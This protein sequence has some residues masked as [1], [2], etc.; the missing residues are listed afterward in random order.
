MSAAAARRRKQ[1]AKKAAA[2]ADSGG[3]EEDDPVTLR[4]NTLLADTANSD[5]ST[6]YEALQLAQSQVRRGVKTGKYTDATDLAYTVGLSLLE[7]HG[8]V[9][10]ASQLLAELV[11]VLN[12][13]HTDCTAEWVKRMCGLDSAYRDALE[14]DAAMATDERD[15]LGR[16]HLKFLRSA[17]KWSE[18]LGTVRFGDCALH[19]L[20]GRHCWRMSKRAPS[21][22]D[23]EGGAST[24]EEAEEADMEDYEEDEDISALS[25]RCEAV[26]HL[27]LSEK[28]DIL[29]EHLKTLPAPTPEEIKSGH[30]CPPAERDSLLTRSVLVLAAVENLRDANV[31]LRAYMSDIEGRDSETLRKS[32]MSKTDGVAPS[33]V[34]FCCMVLRTCEKSAKTGPLYSWLLRSFNSELTKIYKPDVIKAYTTKIGKVYFNIQPPPSMMSTLENM[35][36]MMGGGGM[37]GGMGGAPGGMNPA[38]MQAMMQQMQGM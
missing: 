21:L 29:A 25:L 24:D 5:E 22:L 14:R 26:T 19:E 23:E 34:I 13:T 12:E 7:K 30:V 9:S 10:V 6:A 31:L 27:A 3:S 1:L 4:L 8:R 38:M 2:R 36:G 33:H 35:M 20:L 11:R 17:L 32:Y 28:P 15:R 16:L 18:V 37:G